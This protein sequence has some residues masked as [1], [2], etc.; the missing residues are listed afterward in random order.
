MLILGDDIRISDKVIRTILHDAEKS[1]EA[2]NLVYV[3]DCEPGINRELF[4]FT[5]RAWISTC[6]SFAAWL[7]D[8]FPE[9]AGEV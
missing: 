2:A 4:V 8:R 1:A 7:N 6:I 5:T 9:K 3:H